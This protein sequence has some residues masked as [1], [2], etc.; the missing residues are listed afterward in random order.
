MSITA[1]RVASIVDGVII[2]TDRFQAARG[3]VRAGDLIG[4]LTGSSAGPNAS[5]DGPTLS[6]L[7]RLSDGQKRQEMSMLL[8]NI[9][10]AEEYRRSQSEPLS[11]ARVES[12][13]ATHAEEVAPEVFWLFKDH[14]YACSRRPGT[15]EIDEV[16]LRIKADHFK[17]TE[18]VKRLREQVANF[19]AI[20]VT[21][22]GRSG[23]SPLPDDV[24]LLVWA[25]DGGK[26]VK[27][28]ASEQLHFDHII[29]L[30]KGGGDHAE[31]IQLL[32][33]RCNLSKGGRLV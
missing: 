8:D 14:I 22:A 16:V 29:P 15:A 12:A 10:S 20:E 17:S 25:R 33:R 18:S 26:C 19:E 6:V 7:I 9:L 21:S 31:N 30:S 23:R 13:Q 3:H 32:C 24:K 27:C 1:V 5:G 2:L 4:L 28:G 11:L